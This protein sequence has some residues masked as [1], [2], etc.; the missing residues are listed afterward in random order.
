[1]PAGHWLTALDNVVLTPHIA[2]GSMGLSFQRRD[3][4]RILGN[5]ARAAAGQPLAAA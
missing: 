3:L 5:V 2:A 4:A 1:L